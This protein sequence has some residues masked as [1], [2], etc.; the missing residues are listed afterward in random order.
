MSKSVRIL[1]TALLMLVFLFSSTRLWEQQQD[2]TAGSSAYTEALALAT[3]GKSPAAKSRTMTK[4]I[5]P[6]FWNPEPPS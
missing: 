6:S 3:S 5:C 1:L 4:G 2:K